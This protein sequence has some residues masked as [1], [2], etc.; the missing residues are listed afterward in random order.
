[1]YLKRSKDT[2]QSTLLLS[3]QSNIVDPIID[4]IYTDTNTLDYVDYVDYDEAR[5]HPNLVHLWHTWP[6]QA[7]LSC[8]AVDFL[9][10]WKTSRTTTRSWNNHGLV[11]QQGDEVY[12]GECRVCVAAPGADRCT[13]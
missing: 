6:S 2:T 8:L 12:F 1:M 11:P 4:Y 9:Q 13:Q 5:V 10:Q 3:R 7:D